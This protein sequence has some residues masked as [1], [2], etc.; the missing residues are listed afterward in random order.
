MKTQE[1]YMESSVQI[2]A[3]YSP[4]VSLVETMRLVK[5]SGKRMLSNKEADAM[6]QN[7]ELRKKYYDLFPCRTGTMLISVAADQPFKEYA[8]FY[9]L[10]FD[11][12]K[13][14]QSMTN[15]ALVIEHPHWTLE[16]FKY[17]VNEPY[18]EHKINTLLKVRAEE[19]YITAID[20][21]KEDGWYRPDE[22]FGVPNGRPSNSLDLQARK[23]YRV[24]GG[25]Y[26]GPLVRWDVSWGGYDDR[27]G[28]DC[29][30][31][32]DDGRGVGVV[33]PQAKPSS[34]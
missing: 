28:V 20:F 31:W 16:E 12:P 29:L 3:T 18:G 1:A 15:K 26:I 2:L 27:R 14:F 34:K 23:L 19:K 17:E 22:T 7:N 32:P 4:G 21:P 25:D 24:D 10:V 5:E 13:K 11:I 6:L 8:K 33:E 9:G 30:G